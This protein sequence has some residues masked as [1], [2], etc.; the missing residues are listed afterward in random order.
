MIK[1]VFYEKVGRRYVPV[2]EWNTDLLGAMPK[3]THIIMCYPGGQSTRYNIDPAFGPMIAAGRFAE[4]AIAEKIYEATKYRPGKELVTEEQHQAW[5][6]LSQAFGKEMYAI[7]RV[8]AAEIAE[9]GV[10]A[11]QE[12]AQ[13]L[14]SKPGV[15]KAYDHFM[16]MCKLAKE[17]EN[18][19]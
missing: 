16:L 13:K 15:R 7:Q 8:S 11:M 4:N 12:E 1:K 6:K 17:Q 10:R 19:D 9:E 5:N 3:G 14:L 2:S 18:D